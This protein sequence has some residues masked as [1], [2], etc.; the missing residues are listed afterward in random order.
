V[1]GAGSW[2]KI[3]AVRRIFLPFLLL[4]AS[5]L[6]AQTRKP[7]KPAPSSASKLISIRVT[8]STRYTPAQLSAATGLQI[9]QVVTD[10]DF[11]EVSRHLGETG[12]FSNVAYT[13]QF[14]PEGIRLDVQVTDSA[15]FVPVRF[16]NFVWLS[17][18]ELRQKLS[19]REPLFQD[20]LP[21]SGNLADQVSEALQGLAIE[22]NLHG[23]VDYLRAGPQD[24][25]IEA[26][27][28]SI[29]GQPIIIRNIDFSGAGPTE[30]PLLEAAARRVSRQDYSRSRLVLQ[31]EKN[32]LPVFLEHG[33][34]NAKVAEPQPKVVEETPDE[35]SVDVTFPVT[36]GRQY[37]L[38]ELR[39]LG[40]KEVFTVEN[41][42]QMIHLK[43]DQPADTV[44]AD[45][46]IEALKK[47]YGTR[48]YMGVQISLTP[49]I[50]DADST[51]KL[52]FAFKEGSIYKMG[53]LEVRGLDSKATERIG[54]DWKLLPGQTYNSD[55][56]G[57]FL[58]SIAG[59]FPADQW[60]I[61]V[62]E[63]PEDQDKVVDVSLRFDAIR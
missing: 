9:G 20:Q 27:E 46:D 39:L 62:H 50:N 24:G 10:D 49:E 17:D 48:G 3:L 40:Y 4:C 56:P 37:K 36:P 25:P 31:A 18:Q 2:V 29:T 32:F 53:D 21:V 51:V 61:T 22:R 41:L 1:C 44:Q 28:F 47:L 13:F 33:Y 23:R 60:K 16:E 8:G 15:P 5:L 12:A 11:K 57:Q 38:S 19:A 52:V 6:S 59:T 7:A 54:A 34:L 42:R 58:K 14:N 45:R 63:T 35:T 55:Y 26:F 43:L 30:L